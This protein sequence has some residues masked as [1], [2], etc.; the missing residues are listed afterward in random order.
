MKDINY[1]EKPELEQVEQDI[2]QTTQIIVLISGFYPETEQLGLH[3]GII[4]Y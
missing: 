4:S 1:I 2:S 3:S